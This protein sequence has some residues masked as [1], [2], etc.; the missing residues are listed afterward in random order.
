M[1]ISIKHGNRVHRCEHQRD[2]SFI[3][4]AFPSVNRS[5]FHSS[6]LGVMCHT[7]IRCEA[8]CSSLLACCGDL[9]LSRLPL[10]SH[11]PAK[12]AQH[13]ETVELCDDHMTPSIHPSISAALRS[14]SSRGGL[15]NVDSF[16][17]G[18]STPR[19]SARLS[20]IWRMSFTSKSRPLFTTHLRIY[21]R[22]RGFNIKER[23]GC[24][25]GRDYN[26]DS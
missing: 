19:L 13:R 20:A 10:L 6:Q 12:Q 21:K 18:S 7:F 15:A 9:V 17:A 23:T 25:R 1:R 4:K 2:K 24:L 22:H 26:S 16:A 14:A 5:P 3:P 11:M 8:P